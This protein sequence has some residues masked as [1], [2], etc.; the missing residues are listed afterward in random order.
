MESK[1]IL[2]GL[3]ERKESTLPPLLKR[4]ENSSQA[5]VRVNMKGMMFAA[6]FA[7]SWKKKGLQS[8]ELGKS[9]SDP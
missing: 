2:K 8:R 4:N 3:G 9:F 5:P 7:Y 1:A 6:R